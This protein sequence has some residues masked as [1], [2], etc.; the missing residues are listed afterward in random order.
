M[1]PK[2]KWLFA[3]ALTGYLLINFLLIPSKGTGDV[4]NWTGII[5]YVRLNPDK[6]LFPSCLNHQCGVFYPVTYPPGHFLVVYLAAR[7][8]PANVTPLSTF[9]LTVALFYLLG[10]AA[11]YFYN[12]SQSKI[13]FSSLKL[14]LL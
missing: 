11:L 6:N 14:A 9:K 2:L 3:L 12:R 4:E 7:L 1:N 8:F 13:K 10:F 5:S